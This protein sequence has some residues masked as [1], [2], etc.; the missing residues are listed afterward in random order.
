MFEVIDTY[1][2]FIQ[3][4]NGPIKIGRAKDPYRRLNDLQV[5]SPY[6]LHLLYFFPGGAKSEADTKIALRDARI[7]GDWFWPTERIFRE[8]EGEKAVDKKENWSIENWNPKMDFRDNRL[9]ST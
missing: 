5:E 9:N 6:Q 2:Y 3:I 8:I 1:I 4:E 7:R